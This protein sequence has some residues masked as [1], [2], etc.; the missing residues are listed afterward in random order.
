MVKYL[1]AFKKDHRYNLRIRKFMRIHQKIHRT[2]SNS[3]GL[4]YF[5]LL[6][7][8]LLFLLIIFKY[9]KQLWQG[10]ALMMPFK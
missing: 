1:K 3:N 4:T 6:L 9:Y 7:L 2:L 8:P 5:Q 10:Y